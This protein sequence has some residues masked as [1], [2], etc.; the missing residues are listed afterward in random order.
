MTQGSWPSPSN[1]ECAEPQSAEK[2]SAIPSPNC[3]SGWNRQAIQ[4]FPPSSTTRLHDR[5]LQAARRALYSRNMLISAAAASWRPHTDC[6]SPY[7]PSRHREAGTSPR[8]ERS[9]SHFTSAPYRIFTRSR[10]HANIRFVERIYF[11]VHFHQIVDV[12]NLQSWNEVAFWAVTNEVHFGHI[13]QVILA[14]PAHYGLVTR[15]ES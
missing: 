14:K 9:S 2:S 5:V 7:A 3:R 13:S 11:E 8:T 6:A 15:D 10:H 4:T 1:G 12:K